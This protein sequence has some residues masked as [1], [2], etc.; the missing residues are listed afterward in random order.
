[1]TEKDAL[2]DT[3]RD[4]NKVLSRLTS[5][6]REAVADS[7]NTKQA[8]PGTPAGPAPAAQ[9][10]PPPQAAAPASREVL[11]LA[12]FYPQGGRHYRDTFFINLAHTLERTVKKQFFLHDVLSE[13]VTDGI[14]PDLPATLERCRAAGAEAVFFI[15]QNPFPVSADGMYCK[16]IALEKVPA[17]FYYVDLIVDMMLLKKYKKG[18]KA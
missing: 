13:E 2:D 17:R 8:R 5:E 12:C 9:Q 16:A 6:E 7:M 14:A 3:I 11:R 10:E 15:T 1:M 18:A 4:L